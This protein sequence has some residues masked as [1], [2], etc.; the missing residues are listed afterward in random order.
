MTAF[1]IHKPLF[2]LTL[3]MYAGCAL[4]PAE[5][6]QAHQ[7]FNLAVVFDIDGTL[8]PDLLS[9]STPREDA[10]T[11]VQ[12]YAA[13]GYAIVYLSA[14]VR[15]LQSGIPD[16]LADNGFPP[17]IIH[18]PQRFSESSDPVPFKSRILNAYQSKGW[19]LFAAY[20]DSSEDFE[21]YHNAGIDPGRIFALRGSNKESCQPG[22]WAACLATWSTHLSDIQQTL[23]TAR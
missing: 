23:K 6:P 8:T 7:Q 1:S 4:Q 2:L 18:V 22:I 14:R 5:I 16:W 10:A 3:F 21:A 17:G 15:W 13:N 12:H 20:G 11:A 9:I 19:Q